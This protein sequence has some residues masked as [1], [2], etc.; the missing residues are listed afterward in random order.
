MPGFE[1]KKIGGD[2]FSVSFNCPECGESLPYLSRS[3]IDRKMQLNENFKPCCRRV[4]ASDEVIGA[5][6]LLNAQRGKTE[7]ENKLENTKSNFYMYML[8]G[9]APLVVGLMF[10][11]EFAIG[12]GVAITIL[13]L[14]FWNYGK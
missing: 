3:S 1:I 5:L 14:I 9:V 4:T 2:I 7:A 6:D 12:L 13:V 11:N 8:F 10:R